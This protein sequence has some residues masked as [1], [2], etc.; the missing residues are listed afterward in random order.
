M[1]SEKYYPDEEATL[2]EPRFNEEAME[3]ARPVVP[4]NQVTQAD[5]YAGVPSHSTARRGGNSRLRGLVIMTAVV[6]VL[7]VAAVAAVYRRAGTTAP[8]AAPQTLSEADDVAA[9]PEAAPR[10]AAEQPAARQARE[11]VTSAP[12]ELPTEPEPR[13]AAATREEPERRW[14]KNE[15]RRGRDEG[16]EAERASKDEKK[17]AKRAE[18]ESG[19]LADK[20]GEKREETRP[21]LVGVYTERRKP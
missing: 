4:L 21:R 1:K 2:V 6:A 5:V 20:Q 8:S 16:K 14:H 15:E 12:A 10:P 11:E 3:A 18:K 17:E 13:A 9:E 19:R 7:A